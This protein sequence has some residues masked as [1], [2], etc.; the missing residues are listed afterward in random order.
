MLSETPETWHVDLRGR[1][2]LLINIDYRVSL[3]LHGEATYDGSVVLETPF[4][5]RLAGEAPVTIEPGHPAT[6]G[7]VLHC[8]KKAVESVA[9]SRVD[10]SLEVV[11]TDGTAIAAVAHDLYEAWEVTAPGVQMFARPGGGEPALF[12]AEDQIH[13]KR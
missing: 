13:F 7:P 6:L 8:F 11:F 4:E 12:L 10:S 2:V 9:A 5:L 3:M 1:E